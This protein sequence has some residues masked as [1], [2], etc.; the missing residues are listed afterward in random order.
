MEELL[1]IHDLK[2]YFFCNGVTVKAVDGVSFS[3]NKGQTVCVVGESGCGK[4]ITALSIFRLVSHPGKIVGGSIIFEGQE[5]MKKSEEEMCRIRGRRMSMIFQ[6]PMTALNP[7]LTLGD[8]VSEGMLLHEQIS[9]DEAGK[10][11]IELLSLVGVPSPAERMGQYPHQLS[12]GLRQRIMIA[13]ALAC[14]PPLVI[15][16][17]PTTALDVTIQAQILDLIGG[18]KSRMGMALLLITHNLGVVASVGER[19]IVMYA[20][21]IVEDAAVRTIFKNPLHPYTKGLLDSLPHPSRT[22]L[23]PIPGSVP[24]LAGLPAGCA[25]QNRCPQVKS[26]CLSDEP[27]LLK[28]GEDHYVRCFV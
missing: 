9:R 7:V 22:R 16:D 11:A 18:L 17:E 13:M 12:G 28:A 4:S 5:L 27:D 26:K 10:R 21:R 25:F 2:T 15:A 8:Q 24:S 20:G 3:V 23:K 1:K 14:Q 19:V 6:E